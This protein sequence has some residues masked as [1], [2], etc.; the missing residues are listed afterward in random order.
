MLELPEVMINDS[1]QQ[2]EK[3]AMIMRS[4]GHCV[5][6]ELVVKEVRMK[7]KLD[8]DPKVFPL[9][10]DHLLLKFK[11]EKECSLVLNGGPR[12]VAGQL[13]AMEA[14][15][16]DFVLGRQSIQKVVVWLRLPG[17]PL[18]YWRLVAILAIAA[19]AGRPISLDDFTNLLK[20]IGYACV[21]VELDPGKPFN[22]GS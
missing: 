1:H 10:E 17:L 13:M 3:L 15:M 18:E 4:L 11:S 7:S 22:Q 2:L 6:V 19:E 21:R 12:F 20:K 16:P 14:W 8:Y 9:E 5:L